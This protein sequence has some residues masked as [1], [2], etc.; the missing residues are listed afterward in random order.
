MIE[1]LLG[2][3]LAFVVFI[4]VLFFGKRKPNQKVAIPIN[5]ALSHEGFINLDLSHPKIQ[6]V[7]EA[8]KATV[9][10]NIFIEQAFHRTQD[11]LIICWVS[12]T[13]GDNNSLIS[14]IP[15]RVKTG[16]WILF[17][18][19]SIKGKIGN[20]LRKGNELSLSSSG[21]NKVEHYFSDQSIKYS[22][23]YIHKNSFTPTFHSDFYNVL[24]QCGN[25]V[26]RS[27]GSNILI[28]RISPYRSESWEQEVKELL[29]ITQLMITAK[30]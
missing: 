5:K 19:P 1:G 26:I 21:F 17:Y 29:K 2:I 10:Y 3:F 20:I 25:V 4:L 13:E 11:D 30:F 23:L 18:L 6:S 28:E 22:E 8:F 14:V 7:K 16:R 27:T 9:P 24:Q 15:Q 12:N